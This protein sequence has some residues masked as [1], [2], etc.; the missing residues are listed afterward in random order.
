MLLNQA[1]LSIISGHER[2]NN[3]PT[4]KFYTGTKNLNNVHAYDKI[5]QKKFRECL[6][7]LRTWEREIHSPILRF[8]S[9]KN[10]HYNRLPRIGSKCKWLYLGYILSN[11]KGSKLWPYLLLKL[12]SFRCFQLITYDNYNHLVLWIHWYCFF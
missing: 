4:N 10:V 2:W 8:A 5:W 6:D 1:L 3:I 12:K 9:I 11:V 7:Y